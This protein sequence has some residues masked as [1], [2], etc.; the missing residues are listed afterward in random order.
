MSTTDLDYEYWPFP[1]SDADTAIPEVA[2]KIAF[3]K[4]IAQCTTEAYR[5]GINNY[6][7]KSEHRAGIILERGRKRWEIRLSENETRHLTAFVECFS[8]AGNAVNSWLSGCGLDEVLDELKDQL[9][10]PPGLTES[11]T[12]HGA[13]GK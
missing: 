7:A 1:V 4:A 5:F 12:I 11:Y 6:G 10:I 9:V 3:L 2:E 13:R 8:V